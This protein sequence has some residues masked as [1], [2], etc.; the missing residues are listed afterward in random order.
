MTT[1]EIP[2]FPIDPL[3][4]RAAEVLEG[5]VLIEGGH[6]T[7]KTRTLVFRIGVLLERGLPPDRIACITGTAHGKDDL[8][9]RLAGYSKTG[10]VCSQMFIGSMAALALLL[11]HTHRVRVGEPTHPFTVRESRQSEAEFR[12]VAGRA[13]RN[14][15]LGQDDPKVQPGELD[16]AW[17]WYRLNRTRHADAQLPA[18]EP[19]WRIAADSYDGEKQLEGVVDVDDLV[20]LA[21]RVMKDSERLR[22]EWRR[23]YNHYVVDDC[24]NFS[25]AEVDL[26]VELTRRTRAVTAAASPNQAVGLGVD[27]GAWPRLALQM[28]R[29]GSRIQQINF[30]HRSAQGLSR[31]AQA[32]ASDASMDGLQEDPQDSVFLFQE[33]PAVLMEFEGRPRDMHRRVVTMLRRLRDEE[34]CG[35]DDFACIYKDPATFHALRTMLISQGIPYTVLGDQPRRD[36][37]VAS[38]IA[39]LTLVQN[40]NDHQAFRL[41][42]SADPSPSRQLDS[43]LASAIRATARRDEIDLV[44]AAEARLRSLRYGTRNYRDLRYVGE[45]WRELDRVAGLPESSVLELIV[46][47]VSLLYQHQRRRS[48]GDLPWPM[49]RL[50]DASHP[51]RVTGGVSA[52]ADLAAFLDHLN[53]GLNGDFLDR[54]PHAPLQPGHGLI[55]STIEAFAGLEARVVVVLDARDDV[56]PGPV[57]PGDR[58]ALFRVQRQFYVAWT[59]ASRRLIFTYATRSGSKQDGA[60][61]SRFLDVLGEEFLASDRAGVGNSQG[62][63][64]EI[65]GCRGSSNTATPASRV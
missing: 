15:V 8:M 2:E 14:D 55:C 41:A 1:L 27:T 32:I 57:P 4:R 31:G 61:P 42:A 11:L 60:H 40:P 39:M 46:T 43:R 22:S 18:E 6:G 36:P 65:P 35:W 21:L 30:N 10:D 59:R 51:S 25:R 58:L 26:L 19:W 29:S 7:G 53:P 56:L 24:Q 13:C 50:I 3:Q 9:N 49:K 44:Q 16:A 17:R 20:P 48:G 45:S 63:H 28:N 12:A 38:V 5:P 47:A 37:D 62:Y 34:N 52:A 54:E 23:M 64:Q 33:S